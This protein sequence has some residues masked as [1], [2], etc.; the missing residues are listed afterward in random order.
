MSDTVCFFHTVASLSDRFDSLASD[1]IQDADTFHIVDESVLQELLTVGEM[2]PSVTRR[3]CSQLS[4]AEDAGADVV[5]DT[6]SSTSPAVDIAREMVD[7]PIIKIDDPMTEA[8]VERGEHIS[9]VATASSTLE[10]STE[11]VRSKADQA[12]K[13]VTVEPVFVDGALDARE[14]GDVDRHDHLV[15]ER[16]R[17]LAAETDVVILAQASMSHLAPTLD[18]EVAVPVLSSPDLAMEAV[19]SE[20]R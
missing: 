2:T 12:G 16:V 3:I 15:S 17:E 14:G 7:I 13:S 6:C 11:L 19:A 1:Y 18:D 8:A 4:L 10:P 20:I 5:L 9:V